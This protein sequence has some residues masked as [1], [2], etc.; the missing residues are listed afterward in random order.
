MA[1]V[2]LAAL[3]VAW[4]LLALAV[5]KMKA[6]KAAL[7]AGG[8]AI[9]VAWTFFGSSSTPV[10]L[11]TASLD[12]VSLAL[13]PICL[14]IL[15]ALF[16]YGITVESGAMEIIRNGLSSVSHDRRVLALLIVWGFGN[17]M[18]GMAG[19]GT[20]VAIPASILVGIGFDPMKA[21]LMCLVANTTPTAFGSVGVPLMTLATVSGSET[22][23]L[24]WY[25]AWMQLLVTAA[26][27]FLVLL[28][29]DGW[30]GLKG[31]L[32]ILVCTDIAFL[33]PWI[34][35]ARY[36]G[37]EL[38]D[39]AGGL[40]VMVFLV[41][42]G[43]ARGSTFDMRAQF[44]AWLPFGVVVLVL[45]IGAFL[46]TAL[47]RFL[48]PGLLIIA[49]AFIGGYFQNLT[50]LKMGR[51]LCQTAWN[52]RAAFGMICAVLAMSSVMSYAGMI[53]AIAEFL[54][55]TAGQFYPF[56]AP[57]VGAMGGFVTGSGTSANVLFGALQ[58][59]AAA[60][61]GLPAE[62]LAAANVMGAGI[63]KMIC[64][65]SIAIGA[66]AAGLIGREGTIMKRGILWF[67]GVIFVACVVT[68]LAASCVR[69]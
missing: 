28:M 1:R 34:S 44:N 15:A 26:G 61:L 66:A 50:F 38:P 48:S 20:A 23:K 57:L 4:L 65:Q 33:I 53:A 41:L 3:P 10:G 24:V 43:R 9:A 12:G 60:K 45:G 69:I 31:M 42:R 35:A 59:G 36:L 47:K 22:P 68:S 56:C 5:L 40:S 46:P 37:Y 6:W 19:F 27:P 64:P 21:V 8:L 17:F 16:T 2:L 30:R 63:G 7:V 11:W 51:L 52:Y 13:Y 14:V 54:V 29:L 49:A 18:E 39:I 62:L 58:A 32:S 25:A 67:F 55:S